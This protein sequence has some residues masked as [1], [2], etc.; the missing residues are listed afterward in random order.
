MSGPY[1][2][3]AREM[4]SKHFLLWSG[5]LATAV[6]EPA[7]CSA[8]RSIR[9]ASL[10]KSYRNRRVGYIVVGQRL[11]LSHAG[12]VGFAVGVFLSEV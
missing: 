4:I 11:F 9:C 5:L 3:A 2:S 10:I 6:S 7:D 1:F 12:V 8:F